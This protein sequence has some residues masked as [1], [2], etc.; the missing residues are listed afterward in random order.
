MNNSFILFDKF[1]VGVSELGLPVIIIFIFFYCWA[2][3]AFHIVKT[4]FGTT[5]CPRT[6]FYGNLVFK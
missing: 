2:T 3:Y 4:I 5:S 1:V 6:A